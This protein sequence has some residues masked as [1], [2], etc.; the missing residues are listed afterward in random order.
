MNK[1]ALIII[2]LVVI[3]AGGIVYKSF[4]VA[5]VD[6]PI[7]T[8]IVREITIT[9]RENSWL[10]DPPEFEA[11]QGD[12]LKMTIVNEDEYDHGFAIDAFGVSQ[13][14]PAKATITVEFVATQPG[15]FPYYCSVPCGEGEV[16]GVKR[17]HFDQ[18][19]K[20]KVR[21]AVRTQ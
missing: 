4:F 5:E 13:R 1:Y 6:K 17:G 7:S 15:E 3:V 19:G 14:V 8:G 18:V 12:T 16:N 10:W 9:A 2:A 21:S 11:N 20:M